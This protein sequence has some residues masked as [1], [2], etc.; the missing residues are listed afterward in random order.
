MPFIAY[1]NSW[2]YFARRFRLDI[3]GFV[4]PKPG[5]APSPFHIASLIS[6]MQKRNARIIIRQPH[7]PERDVAFLAQRTGS[8][9]V[10]L[11]SSV[12]AT[13]NARD[14]LALFDD[15]ISALIAAAAAVRR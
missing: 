7:E 3:I 12:G 8:K 10:V 9:V 6:L 2:A 11:A 14:Y 5:V 13:A 15:N 1:H 4:E